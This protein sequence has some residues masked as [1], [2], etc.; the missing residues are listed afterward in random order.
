MSPRRQ[1][2][3][4]L[5]P[6]C[7]QC[8]CRKIRCDKSLPSCQ[9]CFG[10][11]LAC[12]R[13]VV[14]R[15]PGRKKGSGLVIE[16]LRIN[17]SAKDQR[18]TSNLPTRQEPLDRNAKVTA[19]GEAEGHRRHSTQPQNSAGFVDLNEYALQ[20]SNEGG[21]FM[22]EPGPPRVTLPQRLHHGSPKNRPT[23]S[24]ERA[25]EIIATIPNL[26]L[27]VDVFFAELYPI[28]PVIS[29]S[30]FRESLNHQE[31]LDL[32]Q[33]CLLLSIC[34]LTALH[35]EGSTSPALRPRRLIAQ[36]V[37]EQCL[38]L[39]TTFD[40]IGTA[41]IST[42][43]TSL[44]L[45]CAEVEF[46]RA[47]SSWFLLRE[48]IMLAQEMGFY[49]IASASVNLSQ[50]AII[51]LQRTLYLLSLTE[52][53]LTLLRNKPFTIIWLDSPPEEC[54]EDEN[55]RIIYGLQCL[56]LLFKLLDKEF[57]DT[58]VN[59][60]KDTAVAHATQK[61]IAAQNLLSSTS[62]DVENLT[63]IHKADILI[64]QQWLR[65]VFWQSSMRQ[66]LLSSV[67]SVE[68][69]SYQYPCHIAKSLCAV[70]ESLPARAI[71]IHGMAIV[72][73]NRNS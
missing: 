2:I 42:V 38:Q 68:A 10:A 57:L 58:W 65:L 36:H 60:S 62:F 39:R 31:E 63:D 50:E 28:W 8:L 33:T 29:E 23:A 73:R 54:F 61:I 41:T 45:S 71:N 66:G 15:Q 47:R 44:F 4:S 16:R 51:S 48:A 26:N 43:Q 25:L 32:H 24:T 56:S 19:S 55:P 1:K 18:W 35:V 52:R 70:L 13:A 49:D 20:G 72:S 11:D 53:G 46:Q 67:T 34:S 6:P 12:T 40:Y 17:G 64:T 37:I 69:L 27:Y 3:S 14:R 30:S 22:I 59:G 5:F 21:C 7:D 9:R